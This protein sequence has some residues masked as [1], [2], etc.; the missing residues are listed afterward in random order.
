MR[1][2]PLWSSVLTCSQ[3]SRQDDRNPS[4]PPTRSSQDEDV[5]DDDFDVE[6]DF[7]PAPKK[8]SK[9]GKKAAGGGAKKKAALAEVSSN[10][11]PK[12]SKG[13]RGG[14]KTIEQIYQKKTQLEHILL[15]PDTYGETSRCQPEAAACARLNLPLISSASPHRQTTTH[16][17]LS[18]YYNRFNFALQSGP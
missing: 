11:A 4:R 6:E 10:A 13:G 3:A 5:S 9:G 15:R 8:A 7:D 1:F 12:S 18:I 16:R 2:C 17:I 14:K